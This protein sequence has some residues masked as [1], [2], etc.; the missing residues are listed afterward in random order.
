MQSNYAI[1]NWEDIVY[2]SSGQLGA[3]NSI[4][5]FLFEWLDEWWKDSINYFEDPVDHQTTR[6][7]FPMPFPDSFAQEE[8]FGVMG[9]GSGT[10]SPFQRVPKKAYYDLQKIWT[11]TSEDGKED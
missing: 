3:G 11:Q 2:N 8:W 6:A 9:Q 10:A 5:G 4:G 1:R 7:V